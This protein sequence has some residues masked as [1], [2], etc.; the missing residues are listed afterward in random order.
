[1]ETKIKR[2]ISIGVIRLTWRLKRE[3]VVGSNPFTNK[4]KQLTLGDNEKK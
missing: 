4:N 2:L 3:E 1:M